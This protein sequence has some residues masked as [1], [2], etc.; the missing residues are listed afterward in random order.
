ML[1]GGALVDVVC[2]ASGLREG[3]MSV[4]SGSFLVRSVAFF[5]FIFELGKRT[6][7]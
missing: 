3:L 7:C 4:F 6:P 5:L 2:W 1:E